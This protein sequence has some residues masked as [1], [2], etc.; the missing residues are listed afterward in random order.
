MAEILD[1]N[2]G[3]T[4][5]QDTMKLLL[6]S[7]LSNVAG[8][9]KGLTLPEIIAHRIVAQGADQSSA[10]PAQATLA[11]RGWGTYPAPE[12]RAARA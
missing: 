6:V 1:T 11:D 2:L 7:S 9:A 10:A 3:G 8:G 5:A 12:L 4:D